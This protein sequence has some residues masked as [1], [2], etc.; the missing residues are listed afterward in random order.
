LRFL[1]CRTPGQV[2]LAQAL[3]YEV[4]CRE[5]AWIQADTAEDEYEVDAS[6]E[7]AVHFLALDDAGT[8][9]G[10]SRYLLGSAQELP[11]CEHIDIQPLGLALERVTEV[12][13][14]ATRRSD[15][16]HDLRVFLGLTR[17]MWHWG[18]DHSISAWMAIADVPL[19][20]LLTRLRIPVVA[21]APS[22]D[23]LGSEC[24]PVAYDMRGTGAAL[25]RC[26]PSV[27]PDDLHRDRVASS[28]LY[29]TTS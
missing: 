11:A 23:Y 14:L 16:S 8:A 3:R 15:R 17:L 12:S 25:Y 1:V 5:K 27:C 26:D 10:T 22:V 28:G 21:L 19:Y 7:L 6:D 20:H 13:R 29:D 18:M 24:V 2:R 9:M 4:Y